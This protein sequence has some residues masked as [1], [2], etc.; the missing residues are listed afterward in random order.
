MKKA[1][2]SMAAILAVTGCTIERTIVEQAPTT[3]EV[4]TTTQPPVTQPP[5]T[6][7][8]RR[9]NETGFIASI[10]MEVGSMSGMESEAI[11]VGYTICNLAENGTTLE[12]LA[13]IALESATDADGLFFLNTVTA[14]ALA[15]LCPWAI[16]I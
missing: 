16:D 10:E 6:S 4:A 9:A 2:I 11:E 13:M 15:F 7:P 8:V 12:E 1:F 14:S 3:T 5:V